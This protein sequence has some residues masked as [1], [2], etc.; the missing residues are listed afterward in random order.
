MPT[1][2]RSSRYGS[3]RMAAC[4]PA[5]GSASGELSAVRILMAIAAELV[6]DRFV[7]VGALM[8]LVAGEID[9]FTR[10]REAGPA[11]IEAG[12]RATAFPPRGGVTRI[13]GASKVRF[14][15][16]TVMRVGVA[17]S[18]AIEFQPLK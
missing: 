13:A 7:K 6:G 9:M 8:T 3:A 11:V 4:E 17:A 15:K 10:E 18:A 1:V 16:C 12:G 14:L 5:T 2:P